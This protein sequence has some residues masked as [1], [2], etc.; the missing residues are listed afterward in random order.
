MTLVQIRSAQFS[1]VLLRLDGHDVSHPTPDG[2]G[3]VNCQY[4]P[5]PWETF[6]QI[7]NVDGTV[8]FESYSFANVFLRMAGAG[9]THPLGNGGGHINGQYSAGPYEKFTLVHND[10]GTQSIASTVFSNV[11]LR[12]DGDGVTTPAPDGAGV[13]N[14]QYGIGPYEKLAVCDCLTH[15]Q[16]N[17]AIDQLASWFPDEAAK[18]QAYRAQLVGACCPPYTTSAE[19]EASLRA[20]PFASLTAIEEEEDVELDPCQTAVAWAVVDSVVFALGLIGLRGLNRARIQRV[21]TPRIGRMINGLRRSCRF[22]VNS[23]TML[24]KARALFALLSQ[25]WSAIGQALWQLMRDSV[26]SWWEWLKIVVISMAQFAAWFATEGVAFFAE[27]VL[28]LVSAVQLLEDF[29]T[30]GRECS[31]DA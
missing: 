5:G 22:F 2:G 30:V 31:A 14:C 28:V 6:R 18:I 4:G 16:A 20:I 10:D 12:I 3:T 29:A 23:P 25:V 19:L 13:A 15:Q 11:H 24:G 21:I 17:D 1:N 9:V 26:S 27:C 8:S 7:D